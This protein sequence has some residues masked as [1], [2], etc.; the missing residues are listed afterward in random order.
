MGWKRDFRWRDLHSWRLRIGG[1][2]C[3]GNPVAEDLF[4]LVAETG[5]ERIAVILG[6]IDLRYQALEPIGGDGWQGDLHDQ[7]R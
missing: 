3:H 2:F 1:V 4:V 7:L 6:P 5:L